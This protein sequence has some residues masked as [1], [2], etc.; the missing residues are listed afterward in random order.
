[1]ILLGIANFS[2]NPTVKAFDDPQEVAYAMIVPFAMSSICA[3]ISGIK[4]DDENKT[5]KI[6]RVKGISVSAMIWGFLFIV[7]FIGYKSITF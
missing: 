3:L 4:G 6:P 5:G 2:E 1:M 7:I